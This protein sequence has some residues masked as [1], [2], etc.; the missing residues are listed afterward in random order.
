MIALAIETS[1]DRLSV[2]ASAAGAIAERTAVGARRHAGWLV[3]LV[4]ETLGDLGLVLGQ[5]T[6]LALS[7]GPGSFTG[8]RVGAAWAKGVCRGREIRVWTASTLLVR[9]VVADGAGVVAGLGSALRGEFYGAV[10]RLNGSASIETLLQPTV[11]SPV[12]GFG[13]HLVLDAVVSDLPAER[14]AELDWA[15]PA[16]M[17]GAP[18]GAPTARA[19]LGLVGRPGGARRLEDLAGWE[20]DY[21]RPAEAQAR[22][23]KANGRLLADPA[24]GPS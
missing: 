12:S 10:Y 11:V 5:V 23:E 4:L 18:A 21:G 1:T 6:D 20:P 19:L 22:W 24:R 2:A 7:D 17:I 3:P 8:L 14:R 9:A 13:P 15:A 16:R